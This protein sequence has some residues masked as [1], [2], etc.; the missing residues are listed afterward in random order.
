MKK[1]LSILSVVVSLF[2]LASCNKETTSVV[3]TLDPT[4]TTTTHLLNQK[5]F[6]LRNM[7]F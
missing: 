1:I 5:L 4:P 7:T 3:T 2:L 6:M